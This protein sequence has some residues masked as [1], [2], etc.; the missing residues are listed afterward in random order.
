MAAA[1][2]GNSLRGV[3]AIDRAVRGC[4]R[5]WRLAGPLDRRSGELAALRGDRLRIS[6]RDRG[7][8][9]RDRGEEFM[10]PSAGLG[11]GRHCSELAPWWR[12][13]LRISSRDRGGGAEIAERNLWGLRPVWVWVGIALDWHL[14]GKIA[15]GSHAEIAEGAQRSPRRFYGAFGRVGFGSVR[16]HICIHSRW[17]LVPPRSNKIFSAI[18]APTLR[19][20]REKRSPEAH[21]ESSVGALVPL[22]WASMP[23]NDL[24]QRCPARAAQGCPR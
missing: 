4:W 6:S 13:R 5:R 18:S 17:W 14:G 22:R 11:L 10:G 9:R 23:P 20:L 1:G 12:N 7:V 3:F 8:E 2:V 19:S 15:A 16:L 21:S 24:P